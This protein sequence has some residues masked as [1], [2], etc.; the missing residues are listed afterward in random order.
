V[1]QLLEWLPYKFPTPANNTLKL[2]TWTIY[3]ATTSPVMPYSFLYTNNKWI[4]IYTVQPAQYTEL[5]LGK[6]DEFSSSVTNIPQTLG[7]LV[8]ADV[9]VTDTIKK[10]DIVYVSYNYYVS[11][12]ADYQRVQPLEYNGSNFVVPYS[13]PVTINFIKKNNVWGYVQPLPVI[14]HT[15]TAADITL[16]S[17]SSVATASQ[18]SNLASYSDFESSWT[19]TQ[20]DAAFVLVLQADYPT[21]ATNTNYEVIYNAYIGGGDVAS[22]YSFQWN[23]TAWVPQQ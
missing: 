23:G 21:P 2:I 3:P 11:S 15:L 9:T 13:Y 22:T 7:A 1:S 18:L 10:G 16:I 14:S 19:S 4:E 17:Q 5:G 8:N 20:L 6:Y 12:S